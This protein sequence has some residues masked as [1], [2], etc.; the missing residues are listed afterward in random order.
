MV[1]RI[2]SVASLDARRAPG[3][4]MQRRCRTESRVPRCASRVRGPAAAPGRSDEQLAGAM[5]PTD[6][7]GHHLV[8]VA[9][10]LPLAKVDSRI[11]GFAPAC[12]GAT[13]QWSGCRRAAGGF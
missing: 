8:G 9:L 3:A 13:P 7:A 12:D 6:L 11:H 10:A 5:V 2:H 4:Q 1:L